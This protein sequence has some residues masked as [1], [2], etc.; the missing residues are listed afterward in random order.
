QKTLSNVPFADYLTGLGI[1]PGIKVDKGA[2]PLANSPDE[3]ITEGLD[4]LRER[5]QEYYKLG[6]RFAKWRAVIDI[7]EN[8]PTG[9][10]IR[11]NAQALARYAALCQEA[12][13]VPI[14]EPEVLMDGAHGIERCAAVTVSTLKAVFDELYTHGV[15]LEGMILKPNMVISGMLC[16]HQASVEQ[17]A[18]E[19][20]RVLKE[21]VPAAVPGIMFLSG[22]QSAELATAHLNAMNVL[23]NHPWKLSFSYGRALQAPSLE[24]WK[25]QADRQMAGQKALIHRAACNSSACAGTYTAQMEKAA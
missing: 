10:C 12:Q 23:S 9:Y 7:S 19:T 24:A 25:G 11:A 17:V 4:G 8:I 20:L 1:V 14:V 13:I 15:A 2:K 3:K 18:R 22:G 6:A 16:P 5:L 21:R